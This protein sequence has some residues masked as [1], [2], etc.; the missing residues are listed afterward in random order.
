[1]NKLEELKAASYSAYADVIIAGLSGDA[2]EFA[3]RWNVFGHARHAYWAELNKQ[4]E[5]E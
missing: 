5:T 4:E 3:D 2:Q 1:M